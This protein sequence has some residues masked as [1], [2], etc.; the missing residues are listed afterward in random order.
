M[1]FRIELTPSEITQAAIAGVMRQVES[2]NKKLQPAY[3]AGTDGDW[4]KHIEGC[5]GECAL[6]RYLNIYWRG[7]GKLR[8]PD[9]GDM[10]VRTCTKPNHRLILHERDDDNRKFWL[11]CGQNGIYEIK[12]WILGKDGKQSKYWLDPAGGRPAF[13]IPQTDLIL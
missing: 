10:D 7:K 2:I 3:G 12:G 4:Q 6:A 1:S 8:A 9:V 11:V 5:L 13:F